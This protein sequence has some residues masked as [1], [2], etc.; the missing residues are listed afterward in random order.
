M[1]GS[2]RLRG[3][4]EFVIRAVAKKF[5]GLW[6]RVEDDPPDAYLTIGANTVA[7]EITT[8]VQRVTD[9]RGTRSRSSDD[10]PITAIAND[11]NVKLNAV[12]P[13]RYSIGLVFSTPI[14]NVR[15]TISDL[16]KHLG[17]S[18]IRSLAHA[19]EVHI[20]GNRISISLHYHE[21][22]QTRKVWCAATNRSSDPNILSNAF[23]ILGDR[24]TEKSK[25]C[26][27]LIGK[28][29]LWL[30]LLNDYFL[31]DASDYER[32]LSCIAVDHPFDMVLL[33]G[34][35]GQVDSLFER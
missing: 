32:A 22:T 15:K 24:I 18:D 5:S 29:P 9:E 8:L 25:K 11:L 6:T 1:T 21:E 4:E 10:A 33:I 17:R 34:R 12:I 35:D 23:H 2:A 14:L 19:K 7:V 26:S 27:A 20:Q 28:Q 13:D 16:T 3:D 30:A 31:A